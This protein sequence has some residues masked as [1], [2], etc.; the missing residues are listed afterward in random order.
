[1]PR[2]APDG[3]LLE[4]ATPSELAIRWSPPSTEEPDELT[5]IVEVSKDNGFFWSPVLTGIRSTSA[6]LPSSMAT[7]LQPLQ[8]RVLAENVYGPGPPAQ[9]VLKIPAR[10]FVPNMAAVK[11][12][13]SDA[14]LGSV[15]IGWPEPPRDASSRSKHGGDSNESLS[16]SVEVREGSRS[17][18][19][20]VASGLKER[21][22]MHHLKP[23]VSTM[24]RIR[25]ANQFGESEPSSTVI[26]NLPIEQLIPDLSVDP[27][28]AGVI[29]PDVTH[30]DRSAHAGLSIHWKEAFLPE[31][32]D[33]CVHGLKPI[34][35]VEWRLGRTGPWRVL[36]DCIVDTTSY[37]LPGHIVKYVQDPSLPASQIPEVRVVC[38][39]EYG[40]TLPTKS[41]RLSNF[42]LPKST[43]E[44]SN[45]TQKFRGR[46]EESLFNLPTLAAS[47]DKEKRPV[48][49]TS[50]DVEN[51]V[52]LQWEEALLADSSLHGKYRMEH[53][54]VSSELA[55]ADGWWKP[56]GPNRQ[57]ILGDSFCLDLPLHASSEQRVRILALTNR[58]SVTGWLNGYRQIRLPSKAQLHPSRVDGLR[59]KVFQPEDAAGGFAVKLQWNK[60]KPTDGEVILE[61]QMVPGSSFVPRETTYRVEVQEGYGLWREIGN[62]VGLMKTSFVHSNPPNGSHLRYR[63]TPI[64][65]YGEGDTV[66]V[67]AV[68]IP[69][70]LSELQG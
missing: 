58:D 63:V 2:T 38:R 60:P 54:L 40:S 35:S 7:P 9:P 44:T 41:L 19:K 27:P 15:L 21:D 55:E 25:A 45:T 64:N 16:Y 59:G 42:G 37:T 65:N 6:H 12:T 10:A 62:V 50:S 14:D 61:R 70:R 23:G 47:D 68:R 39:N 34:Y 46:T 48:Y 31:Y 20:T 22:Y 53:A 32:C 66:E 67:P 29:R 5:Y 3:L 49:L 43:I 24:V 4:R 56:V 8:I 57:P 30:S 17:E 36:E 51:G 33:Q 28:W 26:A 11:P 52:S 1:M 69:K 18:W 13:L